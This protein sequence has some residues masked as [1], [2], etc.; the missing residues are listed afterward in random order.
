MAE[1]PAPKPAPKPAAAPAEAP[2]VEVIDGVEVR[3][4]QMRQA[5]AARKAE[6]EAAA[7]PADPAPPSS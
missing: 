4:E 2:E 6:L 7:A 1:N 5:L 3:T